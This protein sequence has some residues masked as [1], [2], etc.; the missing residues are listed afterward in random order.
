MAVLGF[1]AGW[2]RIV[3]FLV[4]C[5]LW[6][7]AH[8]A[9]STEAV[10]FDV[11][12]SLVSDPIPSPTA[13]LSA[14][15]DYPDDAERLTLAG[16][17]YLPDS[18]L[19]GSGPYPVVVMLHGSGGLWSNDVIANGLISQFEEWGELLAGMGYAVLFPDS[20][21]PRGIPAN[22]RSRRPHYEPERDDHLCSPNYERPKDVVAALSYLATR[23]EVDLERTALIGFSHGA[24][25]GINAIL[26]ASVDLGGYTVSYISLEEVEGSDPVEYE[27]TTIQKAVASPVRI[28]AELPIPKL[29][30]F[31]YGG[32]SH[33]GYHGSASSTAAGRYMFDRRTQVL[34]LHGTADSLFAG[35]Y[36]P[37]KQVR[38][39][40]AQA[41]AEGVEDPFQYHYIFEGVGHSFDLESDADPA[42]WNTANESPDQK[43]KRLARAEVLK[44]LEFTLKPAP[45]VQIAQVGP[46]LSDYQ[47]STDATNAFLQY[48][49]QESSA[50][51]NWIDSGGAFTG[52]VPETLEIETDQANHRFFRLE[53]L[54]VPPPLSAPE[55]S[56]FFRTPDE[57]VQP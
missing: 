44:W 46:E 6:A 56:G 39:S 54:P 3:L 47:I 51:T 48:Q 2:R 40:S 14:L 49:W 55:N 35:N 45:E 24:Q 4:G 53:Y 1:V 18:A 5:F 11:P 7:P 43:A 52:N 37:I 32:G 36:Y 26:D 15:A 41:A 33:Y 50:L 20:F 31:Y 17:F 29:G 8:A 13:A 30:I 57:F 27:E 23:P 25:T 28:P 12:A 21:N 9:I 34:L 42:D 22:F 19:F 10:Y 16:V 38:A